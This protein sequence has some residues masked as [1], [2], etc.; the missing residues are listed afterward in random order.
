MLGALLDAGFDAFI[1]LTE[2]DELEPYDADLPIDVDYVRKPIRD[3]GIPRAARAHGRHP[4]LHS[5]LRCARRPASSTCTAAPA[6]A[7]RARWSAACSSSAGSTGHEALDRAQRA[8]AGQAIAPTLAEVPETDDQIAVHRA[9]LGCQ[10]RARPARDGDPTPLRPEV[11]DAARS[12]RERFQGALVGLAVGDALAAAHAVP[13]ARHVRAPWATCSAAD[14]SNCRAAPGRT[15]RPWRCCSRRACSSAR[16]STPATRC[17]AYARWQRE[18]YCQRH[19]AMRGH[20]RQRRA[21]AGARPS[22]SASCS[23]ARTTPSSSTRRCCRGS[24]R[25]SCTTSRTPAA[26]VPA[27]RPKRRASPCQA[28]MAARLRAGCSRRCCTGARGAATRPRSCRPPRE[29]GST[30]STRAEVARALRG[31]L[32]ASGALGHLGR[33]ATSCRPSRRRCGPSTAARI[34]ARAR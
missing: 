16:A 21:R 33:V 26:A 24:R 6:S 17:S 27:S 8:L 7:A 10:P 14:P 29:L 25:W 18:G 2:P 28:P 22:A 5:T 30:A 32:C 20:L 9:E 13:Q 3:H 12:L 23:P 31:V 4:R 1:D 34:F 11:M 15:T 19:R